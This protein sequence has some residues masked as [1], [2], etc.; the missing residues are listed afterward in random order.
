MNRD[1]LRKI[2]AVEDHS[3][4][5]KQFQYVYPVISRRS[6]GLSIGVN[7]NPGMN[8][9][10]DCLYCEVCR[11]Q[12]AQT[13]KPI[14]VDMQVLKN[15]LL[16]LIE[17]A[18]SGALKEDPKFQSAGDL[19]MSIQDIALSGNGEPTISPQFEQTIREIVD[20][21]KKKE[22]TQT[23]IVLIT[24]ATNLTAPRIR[25]SLQYFME[26]SGVIW[27]KLDAGTESYYRQINRS[28]VPFQ[29]VLENLILTAQTYPI[30][31]QTMFLKLDGV[32]M[33]D[34]ELEQ[35]TFLIQEILRNRGKLLGIQAYT[36]A[37][38][39]PCGEVS[40][41]T[42]EEL[43]GVVQKIKEKVNI[44]IEIFA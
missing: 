18:L 13:C 17:L 37:R 9:T 20:I 2:K 33:S 5:Y 42:K 10:F 28:S 15:E 43:K 22:L 7:L 32:I 41:L 1:E 12:S 31:I 23:K 40:A 24:N 3:R 44:P 25:D 21:L 34:A 26:N 36:I 16:T 38:Q 35:Y 19:T 8:C 27:A 4:N 11:K 39:T 6:G 14:F 30:W 29:K